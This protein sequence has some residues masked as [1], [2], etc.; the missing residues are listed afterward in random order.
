MLKYACCRKEFKVQDSLTHFCVKMVDLLQPPV[1]ELPKARQ[2]R[3]EEIDRRRREETEMN[4]KKAIKAIT[5]RALLAER[6]GMFNEFGLRKGY[7]RIQKL[8]EVKRVLY[9]VVT[10]EE[11]KRNIKERKK[12][13]KSPNNEKKP[14]QNTTQ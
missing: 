6:V 8:A 2:R 1:H 5:D 13:Q 4:M 10:M 9:G 12:K 11:V 7:P 14:M 3:R